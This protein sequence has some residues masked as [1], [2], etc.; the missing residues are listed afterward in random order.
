MKVLKVHC[1]CSLTWFP[2]GVAVE[3]NDKISASAFM[4]YVSMEVMDVAH[5]SVHNGWDRDWGLGT[6][7]WD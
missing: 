4:T 2:L 6:G 1:G 5:K 7:F 3:T